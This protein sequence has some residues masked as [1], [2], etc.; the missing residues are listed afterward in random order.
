[1]TRSIFTQY[2]IQSFIVRYLVICRLYFD[3]EIHQSISA[4]VS[5]IYLIESASP[6][7]H[8]LERVICRNNHFTVSSIRQLAA[9]HSAPVIHKHL[10]RPREGAASHQF[11]IRSPPTR[12]THTQRER[13]SKHQKRGG[14]RGNSRGFSAPTTRRPDRCKFITLCGL[15]STMCFR[16]PKRERFFLRVFFF[17]C[18]P[19]LSGEAKRIG[20][21]R[22]EGERLS[23]L[24]GELFAVKD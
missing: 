7:Y 3:T 14:F 12:D 4:N 16:R 21:R 17:R 10:T 13:Q 1:M 20:G 11:I 9:A 8:T 24:C 18:A 5:H 22:V 23:R 2:I 6:H 15:K 19:R